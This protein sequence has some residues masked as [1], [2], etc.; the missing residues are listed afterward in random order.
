[1][2]DSSDLMKE[3]RNAVLSHIRSVQHGG[4][5]EGVMETLH[6]SH[7]SS[8]RIQVGKK[9]SVSTSESNKTGKQAVRQNITDNRQAGEAEF[10]AQFQNPDHKTL[11]FLHR[12]AQIEET[13]DNNILYSINLWEFDSLG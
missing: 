3:F 11:F 6:Q 1:M 2:S 4:Q 10:A 7:S 12:N 5:A 13:P 9:S 8:N